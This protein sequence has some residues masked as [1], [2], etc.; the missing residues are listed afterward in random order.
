VSVTKGAATLYQAGYGYNDS[1]QVT[2][3]TSTTNPLWALTL[4]Y[5]D[6]Y[7]LTSVT[8]GQT[9]SLDYD[10]IGNV[11][12]NTRVAPPSQPYQYMDPDL[13]HAV[14]KAGP[15]TYAYD[16]N[17]NLT[18]VTVRSA[19]CVDPVRLLTWDADDRLDT[20]TVAGQMTRYAYDG[21]RQ[22]IKKEAGGKK[23]LYFGTL[24]ELELGDEEVT[25]KYYYADEFLAAQKR[26][27]VTQYVHQDH[28]DSLRAISDTSGTK[29]GTRDFA[30]FGEQVGS[31]GSVTL[32]RGYG[33]HFPDT[34]SGLLYM[35]ARY[36]DP[37]IGRFVQRD[38]VVP[39]SGDPQSW[40]AYSFVRN[41][42]LNRTD[43]TGN[44][45]KDFSDLGGDT[46]GEVLRDNGF[47]PEV[48]P[49]PDASPEPRA[50]AETPGGTDY[51]FLKDVVLGIMSGAK[52][53]DDSPQATAK[54]KAVRDAAGEV[55]DF[56]A[57]ASG[58]LRDAAKGKGNFGIGS[59]TRA[60]ADDLGR[61]WVGRNA[62]VAS[63]GKTL[64]S[65]D[66]LRQYRPPSHKP[67]LGRTQANLEERGAG[68]TQWQSNGH[69]D[70]LD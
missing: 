50:Q 15:N 37:V 25:T 24:V 20:A 14:T 69:V 4:G 70:I 5:D 9:Q 61:A 23:T 35:G 43:P 38:S 64:V 21:A 10:A 8:G 6:L 32:A 19:G 39:E 1:A 47:G 46:V 13:P 27:G 57:R 28:L 36:Y 44:E 51:E 33:A 45:D 52:P 63:D 17:G 30:A 42:P 7:R 31:T 22:R 48:A 66:G 18:S 11:A 29:I 58:M 41:N 65:Q 26:G 3:V 55:D 67:G 59:A 2:S 54:A 53:G 12:Y 49:P 62:K 16:K 56:A 34:E 68:Q 60:E 40:N